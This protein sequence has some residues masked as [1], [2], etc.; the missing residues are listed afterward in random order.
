MQRHHQPVD[1]ND[2]RAILLKDAVYNA[3]GLAAFNLYDEVDFDQWFSTTLRQELKLRGTNYRIIRRRVCWL[4]G[5]WAG[6]KLSPRHKPELYR[7]MLE[8]L[9]PEEDLSVRLAASNALKSAIDDFNFNSDEFVPF[10][11]PA[12]SMLFTLLKEVNECDT[13]VFTSF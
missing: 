10:L 6:V 9:S 3:V 8:S 2:L 5:Q 7:L 1:P 11:E 4:I 13:K 12:F